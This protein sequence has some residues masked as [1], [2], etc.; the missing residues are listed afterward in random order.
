VSLHYF[1]VLVTEF[2]ARLFPRPGP[3]REHTTRGRTL[4]GS[5]EGPAFDQRAVR[6]WYELLQLTQ[7][8][9]CELRAEVAVAIEDPRGCRSAFPYFALCLELL[10]I[11]ETRPVLEMPAMTPRFASIVMLWL[12]SI[13][14][15][16]VVE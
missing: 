7:E 9:L 10:L 8:R 12:K 4:V 1:Q 6:R 15:M 11:E 2:P 14:F 16:L 5:E 3:G 13:F